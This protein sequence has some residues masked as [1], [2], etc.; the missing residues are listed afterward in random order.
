MK[1]LRFIP[2]LLLILSACSEN[3]I[4]QTPQGDGEMGSVSIALSTDMRNE[5][6]ATK[7]GEEP[8]VDDFWISIYKKENQMRL[9]SDQFANTKGKAINLNVGE[10]RLVAQHGDSLGCGFDKPYYMADPTFTVTGRNTSVNAVAK[11]ANVKM[12]VVY[13]PTISELYSEYCVMVNHQQHTKKQLKFDMDETRFGYMPGGEV[14]LQFYA[15][16]DGAWKYYQSAPMTYAPNDFVT[17]TITG[18]TSEGNLVINITVDSSVEEK[19]YPIEIPAIAVPQ[20]APVITL[21][22]FDDNNEHEFIEGAKAGSNASASFIAKGSLSHCYLTIESDYLASRNVPAQLDFANLTSDQKSVLRSVG[23]TWDENMA[24]SRTFSF[25][26]FSGVIAKMIDNTKSAAEDVEMARFTLKIEDSVA[27]TAETTFSFVSGAVKATLDVKDYNVWAKK[28]VDPSYSINKGN[29]D[30]LKLQTSTD[31]LIWTNV[32]GA[33]EQNN[34]TYKY[35]KVSVNPSTTYY[36]RAIY[37]D[38]EITA[39]PTVT[40]NTEAAAQLPNSGFEDWTI[41]TLSYKRGSLDWYQPWGGGSGQWWAVNSMKALNSTSTIWGIFNAEQNHRMVPTVSY[42]TNAH[43]D[44][45]SAHLFC[46]MTGDAVTA[47]SQVGGTVN[48]GEL[49]IGTSSSD[50]SQATSSRSFSSRP[51]AIKFHYTYAPQGSEN[52]YVKYELKDSNGNTIASKEVTNGPSASGWTEYV[53]PVEYSDRT[54]SASSISIV[55]KASSSV[56]P[57]TEE[58]KTI[59]FSGN[60]ERGHFGSSLRIDD[61]ELIYE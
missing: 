1:R 12:A 17:F 15:K 11:L 14:V 53:L 27:K 56:D 39:S 26:D 29:M 54:K 5:T 60:N 28:I 47:E 51:D 24:T 52:F 21:A 38:N 42:S 30:L 61:I 3:I 23:F 58:K 16:V 8:N 41:Q 48:V 19:N 50:G 43:S 45:R 18:D 59:E 2:A 4:E 55:F 34:Y 40:V 35:D 44:S 25:I 31:G 57:K 6:V 10:Y 7:A 46:V 37:N 36:L 49:F 9:Y 13:D 20:G 33:P 22:G 32:G